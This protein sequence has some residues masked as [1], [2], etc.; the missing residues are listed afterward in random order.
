MYFTEAIVLATHPVGEGDAVCVLY[1]RDFGKIRA[2]AQGVKKEEAKLRGH[3]EPLT[4]ASAGFV[5]GRNGERLVY[6][7]ALESYSRIRGDFDRLKA[8]R[9]A[10]ALIDDQCFE[11]ERDERLWSILKET[12]SDLDENG[13]SDAT[14]SEFNAKITAAFGY[15]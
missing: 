7:Q 10:L 6:A 8:A 11:G 1:T 14:I 2:L 5:V 9:H 15:G 12:L 3:I 4:R 13:L